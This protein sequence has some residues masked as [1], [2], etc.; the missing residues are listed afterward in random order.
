M[1]NHPKAT[2]RGRTYD[3]PV[4]GGYTGQH[5]A[6]KDDIR[7]WQQKASNPRQAKA[8]K[9]IGDPIMVAIRVQMGRIPPGRRKIAMVGV[10]ID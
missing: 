1:S 9:P 4:P 3:N 10:R 2:T 5:A 8:A 6:F 7:F